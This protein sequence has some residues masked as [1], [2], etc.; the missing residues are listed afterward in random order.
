MD[1]I[2][3]F[4]VIFDCFL[5]LFQNSG[6]MSVMD[7][8]SSKLPQSL[9]SSSIPK[10]IKF[11]FK[12]K[13]G[14][15]TSIMAHKVILAVISDVFEKEFFG[16]LK[17]HENEILIKDAKHEVF[18]V[19]VDYIYNKQPIMSNYDLHFLSS[20]FYLAE[21]YNISALK[22]E[23]IATIFNKE[24]S[25]ENV[26]SVAIIA[27]ET[28]VLEEFSDSLYDRVAMFLLKKF[29]GKL[30]NVFEFFSQIKATEVN[31]LA[32]LKVMAKMKNMTPPLCENCKAYPC[33]GGEGITKSNFVPGA[34][35]VSKGIGSADVDKLLRTQDYMNQF[36]AVMKD[37]G[38]QS[39]YSLN[40][41]Y[42]MYKCS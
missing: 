42:Y 36:T 16:S 15:T 24:I 2:W 31:G 20:L 41:N 40:P 34:S 26:L 1:A 25:D 29:A 6:D 32:L 22:N 19:L 12:E 14:V 39:G 13:E 33:M 18:E 11:L 35:V 23:I 5:S 4:G 30:T 8:M 3:C 7:L 21:K 37:G 27:E 28:I 10:D 9:S 17:E 38:I